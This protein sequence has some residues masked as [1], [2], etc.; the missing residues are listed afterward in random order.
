M[1]ELNTFLIADPRYADVTSSV[2]V[3]VKDGPASV[4]PQSYT[5]NSN[6]Q[7]STVYDINIPSENTLVD[8]NLKVEGYVR[9]TYTTNVS[10]ADPEF[11][12]KVVP[13]AF[14]LNQSLQSVSL[15]INNSKV[16]V[17]TADVLNVITKQYHQ[18]FL[19]QHCQMT[20]N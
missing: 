9:V 8:R 4:I 2:S 3:A 11:R 15:R 7:S 18:K 6:S 12:F 13:A 20:P 14:P 17:Q 19:S 5:H 16:S 10:D 1:S